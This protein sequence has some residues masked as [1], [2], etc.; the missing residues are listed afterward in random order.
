MNQRM[1]TLLRQ[2]DIP[3]PFVDDP[4][5][6]TLSTPALSEVGE[7]VLLKN[8]YEAN[9][10]V[11][12]QIMK[13]KLASNALSIM[14]TSHSMGRALRSSPAY[15]TQSHCRRVWPESRKTAAAR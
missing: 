3:V 10:H 2:A 8:N 12:P 13:I 5:L 14:S 4:A 1:S 9:K 6:G 11:N 15:A 7:F